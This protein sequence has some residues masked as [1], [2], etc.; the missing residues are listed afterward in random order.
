MANT[1]EYVSPDGSLRFMVVTEGDCDV[2]LGFVG[3][4]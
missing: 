3:F 4:S 1:C 2:M